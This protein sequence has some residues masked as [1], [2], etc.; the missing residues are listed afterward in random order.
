MTILINSA[1]KITLAKG[2]VVN[3]QYVRPETVLIT[4]KQKAPFTLKQPFWRFC[5]KSLVEA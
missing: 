1:L 5:V 2:K 3:T 4:K